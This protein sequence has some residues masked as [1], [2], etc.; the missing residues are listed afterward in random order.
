MTSATANGVYDG[1]WSVRVIGESGS[2]GQTTVPLEVVNGIV[3]L[4]GNSAGRVMD[5][6]KLQLKITYFS[7]VILASG[8]LRG[9]A[10]QGVW[11]SPTRAC[12]GH[13][14]AERSA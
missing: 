9:S 12:A 6:G 7:D 1:S 2:C 8:G 14:I 4:G 3:S 5:G 10:G 11:N 13:W